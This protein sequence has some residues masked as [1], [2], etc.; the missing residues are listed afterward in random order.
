MGCYLVSNDRALIDPTRLLYELQKIDRLNQSLS[1]CLEPKAIAAKVTDGLVGEFD[2]SFARLWLVESDR[3]AL[4]LIASAGLYTR[5]DGDFATVPMGAYKVGKI[6]QNC[7]PFLSNQLAQE[8][9][10]KDRQ[11]AIDNNICG[12][13]GLPIAITGKAIGVLA[14]FSHQPM[15]TEFLEVLKILCSS[16]AVALNNALLHRQKWQIQS[17]SYESKSSFD[18]PVSEQISNILSDVRLTLVGTE[19]PIDVSGTYILLKTAEIL[20]D[21]RCS[22]CCLTYKSD[23]L[24][25]SAM[26]ALDFPIEVEDIFSE[27][28]FL[29][30]NIY[31]QLQINI[32]DN[33]IIQIKLALLYQTQ[34]KP[35]INLSHRER[36][37][38]QLLAAGMRDREIAQKLFISDRT[39]K[40]HINNAVTKLK[41]KTRIQAV[42]QAY[43]QGHLTSI[44]ERT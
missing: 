41:A 9:W 11:W 37:I 23:R 22:Y 3:T 29:A 6:A 21:N 43:S 20:R 35:K 2:C 13:A 10:V 42:Y 19:K 28:N 14:V 17:N 25:L 18:T 26:L 8:A 30:N 1:G 7:I 34:L 16:V 32:S 38:I 15:K 31:S 5:L 24:Y 39:V 12:F 44:I 27:I 4:K 36:E 40:F 33:N